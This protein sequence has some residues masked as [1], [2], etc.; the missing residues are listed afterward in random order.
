MRSFIDD[1]RV[2]A[3]ISK[4]SCLAKTACGF[5]LVT[6][7]NAGAIGQAPPP[8]TEPSSTPAPPTA[9]QAPAGQARPAA[10]PATP[11]NQTT[12]E[13]DPTLSHGAFSINT[14]GGE[15]KEDQLKQLLV[16]KT[17]Y[18][19][20]GY[21]D[22]NLEFDDQGRLTG[23]SAT[24]SYTLSQIQINKVKLSKKKME[25]E[26][27][28]YALHFLGA[29]PSDDLTAATDRVKINPKKKAVHI[30]F[31]REDVDKPKKDRDK[32]GK[33]QEK[34]S[35][36]TRTTETATAPPATA[37]STGSDTAGV[38]PGVNDLP[39]DNDHQSDKK[40][41][42]TKSAAQSSQMLLTALDNV[43]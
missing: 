40:S 2:I 31:M 5:I 21:Q 35:A 4:P 18:L 33:K 11:D 20:A 1:L 23:H 16:G 19:R 17:L 36:K 12:P 38:E 10:Q 39:T 14:G 6:A 15:I 30:S 8:P 22:N 24:G 32:G 28:R 25:L 41:T 29:A 26:G 9:A 37:S 42:T 7:L 34:H 3:T 13:K 43:F 27:D